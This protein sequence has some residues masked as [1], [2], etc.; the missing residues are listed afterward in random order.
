MKTI[1]TYVAD[2]GAIFQTEWE[3]SDYEAKLRA[4][5]FTNTA[6]LFNNNGERMPLSSDSFEK[7]FFIF[8]KTE[9]A[10]AYLKEEFSDWD[11]PWTNK[12][13]QAGIWWYNGEHWQPAEE[14]TAIAKIIEIIASKY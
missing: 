3:C 10:A 4:E 14:I 1:V 5:E 2:D 12:A 7:A 13:P 8:A 11:N 9:R 6:F